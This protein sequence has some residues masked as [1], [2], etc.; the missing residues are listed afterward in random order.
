MKSTEVIVYLRAPQTKSKEIFQK[1][2]VKKG[3]C[4]IYSHQK[5]ISHPFQDG[6]ERKLSSKV[7]YSIF[8]STIPSNLLLISPQLIMGETINS[9]IKFKNDLIDYNRSIIQNAS[10]LEFDAVYN[11]S[12]TI[13]KIYSS[14]VSSKISNLFHG[15]SA[16][17]IAFG[18]KNSGKSYLF[19][20]GNE[21]EGESGIFSKSMTD[22]L[23]LLSLAKQATLSNGEFKVKMA[24]YQIYNEQIDDLL[25]KDKQRNKLF[26]EKYYEDNKTKTV[27]KNLTKVVIRNQRDVDNCVKE[28]MHQRKKI[29]TMLN[30]NELKRKSFFIIS[31][32]ITKCTTITDD[33][34][35]R[36]ELYDDNYSMIDFVEMPSSDYG[37]NGNNENAMEDKIIAA[38]IEK[39]FNS[40]SNAI[41]SAIEGISPKNETILTLA[42]KNSVCKESSVLFITCLIPD[43]RQIGESFK[44]A[45]FANWLRNRIENVKENKEYNECN[46]NSQQVNPSKKDIKKR[47]EYNSD[48][49]NL[50]I[51]MVDE[52]KKKLKNKHIQ[53]N[54]QKTIHVPCKSVDHI[55]S[56]TNVNNNKSPID[57]RQNP[58]NVSYNSYDGNQFNNI[59]TMKSISMTPASINNNTIP[60]HQSIYSIDNKDI[61]NLHTINTINSSPTNQVSHPQ[62]SKRTSSQLKSISES[63]NQLN[64]RS[65]S[66]A[67]QLENLRNDSVTSLRP[68]PPNNPSSIQSELATLKSDNII[69]R[70]DINR[71]SNINQNLE[72]EL[73]DAKF[74]IAQLTSSLEECRCSK[75][76]VENELNA[77]QEKIKNGTY[78]EKPKCPSS[79]LLEALNARYSTENRLREYSNEIS[80]MREEKSKIEIEYRLALERNEESKRAYEN[81][82][83]EHMAMKK[84]YNEQI[85]FIEGKI[86]SV[87]KIVERLQEENNGYRRNEDEM[88]REIKTLKEEKEKYKNKY[89]EEKY[90]NEKMSVRME[91]IERDFA[92]V[93]KEKEDE[94]YLKMKAEEIAKSKNESKVRI[95]N[96]L[97]NKINNYKSQR[98]KKLNQEAI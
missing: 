85:D 49:E 89:T 43:D 37:L 18:C 32:Y 98:L 45:K 13:D 93:M 95:L 66:L 31:I 84:N 41:V 51:E 88:K 65:V 21:K 16:C 53:Y 11:E 38:N 62:T 69:Y 36:C 61:P 78:I 79:P 71:L 63:L 14:H 3:N 82:V 34:Y 7:K 33:D 39:N 30:I 64:N 40:L 9:S 81:L 20:G 57:T 24:S 59:N 29:T 48:D 60:N 96:D 6:G 68:N 92:K 25:C 4:C 55:P 56:I 8:T 94:I 70:E 54:N 97:Q 15:T 17:I 46:I 76:K 22:I 73:Q 77:L 28:I 10:L 23:T 26:I 75:A 5:K 83:N 72:A 27:I 80:K 87:N 42:L 19:R 67:N 90:I 2:Q 47:E 44:A 50:S 52:C 58:L 86:S 35:K 91:E 12:D 74:H 1:S